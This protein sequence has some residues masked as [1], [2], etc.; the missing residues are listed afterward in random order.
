MWKAELEGQIEKSGELKTTGNGHFSTGEYDLAANCYEQALSLLPTHD[1]CKE[2]ADERKRKGK[3]NAFDSGTD[4]P[5]A[6]ARAVLHGNLAA[7]QKHLEQR[8][9]AIKNATEALR[10]EPTY[11][12]VRIRRAELYELEDKPHE[13]LEDWKIVIE[14]DPKHINANKALKR[15]P[16]LIEI[17]NEKL[18]AEMMDGLKKLGNVC[19]KPFGLSTD[20]FK[21][22]QNE[23]GSYNIQ[24]QQ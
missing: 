18:K 7:T 13:A 4:E 8:E 20:N 15:L 17:K 14:A 12:K 2:L 3:E 5:A 19:L 9:D 23:S 24:F 21:M 16:P 1:V 11:V 22:A 6:H 10:L